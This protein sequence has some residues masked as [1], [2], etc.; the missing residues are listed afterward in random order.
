LVVGLIKKKRTIWKRGSSR[1]LFK[2]LE[3]DFKEHKISIG[4]DKFF[5]ILRKN[6]LFIH[7]KKCRAITTDSYHHYHK[8]KNLIKDKI[9]MK[10]NEIWVCDITYIWLSDEECFCYL[11]LITD[12]Y[13]RK[14]IGYCVHQTLKATGAVSA[15]S[16]VMS[17]SK[18]TY[19]GCIHHSDRGIQYCC[20]LYTKQLTG[21]GFVISMTED[22]EPTDNAIAERVNRTIKEEFTTEKEISFKNYNEA[23][24]QLKHF[25][26]F[27]N[28]QRPHSSVEWLTPNEAHDKEGELKKYWKT[29]KKTKCGGITKAS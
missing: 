12:M 2:S 7:R 23:K 27:Y 28:T 25:I 6:N 19:K 1:A 3:I 9:P 5:D 26:E 24:K 15:L 8:Y 13:S 22:S 17:Q 4:R 16:M 14:I 20:D 18:S 11:F 10:A 21:N 29:Y